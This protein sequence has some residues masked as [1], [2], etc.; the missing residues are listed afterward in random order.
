MPIDINLPGLCGNCLSLYKYKQ[1]GG[2]YCLIAQV[3]EDYG[4]PAL[5]INSDNR[6]YAQ[7]EKASADLMRPGS[8]INKDLIDRFDP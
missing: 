7:Q 3:I 6:F 1:S 2:Y 8:C 5:P 4:N